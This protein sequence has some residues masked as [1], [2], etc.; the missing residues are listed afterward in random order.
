MAQGK[1]KGNPKMGLIVGALSLNVVIAVTVFWMLQPQAPEQPAPEPPQVAQVV[2]EH[3][4]PATSPSA[5]GDNPAP[6]PPEAPTNELELPE[7]K[8][9]A[10]RSP[11]RDAVWQ[12]LEERHHV[13]RPEASPSLPPDNDDRE[14]L[15]TLDRQYIRQAIMDDLVPVAV[16]CYDT[17]LADDPELAGKLTM[18]F[19]IVGAEEV[20]G[21]VEEASIVEDDSTLASP[22]VRECMRESLMAVEFPAPDGDGRV[23]VNYPFN[24]EP[25]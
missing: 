3:S 17:A 14:P 11:K 10:H 8:L 9:D 7:A 4:A 12:A 19:T 25:E 20:G 13:F 16:D 2:D 24:F 22:F 6:A 15:G 23:E 21:V 5:S 1:A 18:K